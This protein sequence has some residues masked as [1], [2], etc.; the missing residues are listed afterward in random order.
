M[1]DLSVFLNQH[2]ALKRLQRDDTVYLAPNIPTHKLNNAL[3]AYADTSAEQVILLID[4]TVFGSAKDGLLLTAT[5]LYIKEGFG[6]SRTIALNKINSIA[7]KPE[8]LTNPIHI[9]GQPFVQLAQP[10]KS[11]LKALCE[12]L[13]DYVAQHAGQA[14]P[15]TTPAKDKETATA[16][17][18]N[19][20]PNNQSQQQPTKNYQQP[21][22]EP[23]Q[24]QANS[25]PAH[26]PEFEVGL[27]CAD[28][29][30]HYAFMKDAKWTS[31]KVQL[32][33]QFCDKLMNNPQQQDVLKE[34]L[35]QNR[36][37]ALQ[38]S[39]V[40]L[41]R[42][43]IDEDIRAFLLMQAYELLYLQSYHYRFVE[44]QLNPL[45]QGIGLS[46]RITRQIFDELKTQPNRHGYATAD[47]NNDHDKHNQRDNH[48]GNNG[49]KPATAQMNSAIEQACQILDI[50]PRQLNLT[51]VQQAYRN[52]VAEFHPDKYHNLPEAVKTLLAEKT[53]ELN[54]ARQ[55]LLD[56]L[57]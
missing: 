30:T 18:T 39:M 17:R 46:R 6:K 4:D 31:A 56:H 57:N 36:R 50:E 48:T 51:M 15:S 53:H 5:D 13:S 42:Y 41:N 44:Q 37:P 33:R 49:T 52:K 7:L 1:T 54:Q 34:R 3:N 32:V 14:A 25:K 55:V 8:F 20:P 38:E 35:K 19:P 26:D 47:D 40:Q 10:S 23:I 2:P 28:I 43:E 22:H 21:Y 29:L 16:F 27:I 45:A 9:N 12:V 24:P 11:T